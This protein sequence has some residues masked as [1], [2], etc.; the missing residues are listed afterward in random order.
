MPRLGSSTTATGGSEWHGFERPGGE[1]ET[2]RPTVTT[3][4]ATVG[5]DLIDRV[6]RSA[7]RGLRSRQRCTAPIAAAADT[8]DFLSPCCRSASPLRWSQRFIGTLSSASVTDAW[9]GFFAIWLSLVFAG[10]ALGASLLVLGV[11]L[12]IPGAVLTWKNRRAS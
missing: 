11:V 8:S 3:P 6:D 9:V 5:L 7:A 4:E 10:G 12:F 2:A 1:C